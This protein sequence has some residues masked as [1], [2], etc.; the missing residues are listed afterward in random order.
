MTTFLVH[1]PIAVT[2][3]FIAVMIVGILASLNIPVSVMPSIDIPEI[4]VHINRKNVSTRE[5]EN[6][7]VAPLR[8]QLTRVAHLDDISSETR[9]EY[10]LIRLRFEYGTAVDLAFLEVNEKIDRAMT[11]F[12]RD[13]DRPKI[14]KASATDIPVF[15]LNIS[16]KE[17]TDTTSYFEGSWSP[18]FSELSDFASQVIRKRLEQLPDVAMVDMSGLVRSELLVIPDLAQLKAVGLTLDRL[19]EQVRDQNINLGSVLIHDGQYE[20]NIR[21]SSAIRNKKDVEDIYFNA[22]DRLLQLKDF[23]RV[24]QQPQRPK[25]VIISD[26]APAI[27]M[28]II[29]QSDAQMA[30]LRNSLSGIIA[31]FHDDYPHLNFTVTRDQTKLLDYAIS[32]LNQDLIWGGMLAFL[33]MFFF[34]GDIKSPLLIG[35]T[36]P[37]SLI[38]SLICF[39]VMDISINVISLS[40]LVLGVGMMIDNSIIVIDNIV[41]FRRNGLSVTQAC[42]KGSSEVFVPMLSSVLTTCAVFIPLIYL[43]GI[44]GALFFDEAMSIVVGAFVSLVM[45]VT[46]I[47]VYYRLFYLHQ[48]AYSTGF[49]HLADDLWYQAMYERSFKFIMRHQAIIWIAVALLVVAGIFAYRNLPKSKFPPLSKEDMVLHVDW[50]QNIDVEENN[51]RVRSLAMVINGNLQHYTAWVGEQQFL[52]DGKSHLSSSEALLYVKANGPEDLSKIQA[53]IS[54]YL[55]RSFPN[56]TFGYKETDNI[57]NLLFGEDEPQ[58]TARLRPTKDV[59][60]KWNNSLLST[61]AGIQDSLPTLFIEKPAVQ[62][63][64][65]LRVDPLRL[66]AY[67]VD[68]KT[69]YGKLRSAFNAREMLVITTGDGFMPVVLGENQQ[70][71]SNVLSEAYVYNGQGESYPLRELITEFRDYDL[72][73]IVAGQGGQYY[74]LHFDLPEQEAEVVIDKLKQYL[75]QRSLF[76]VDF[77]GRLFSS[78]VLIMELSVILLISVI[79]LYIILA[80]QFESLTLPLIVLLEIPIDIF[81]AFAFLK[82]FGAGINIMSLIGIVVMSGIIINDSILKIDTI[83]RLMREGHSLTKSI[84]LGGQRRLKSILMT[85]ITTVLAM[86]PLLLTPGLGSELQKPLAIALLGGMTVGTFVSLYFIPVCYYHIL[87]KRK[88]RLQL[89]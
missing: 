89:I 9:D 57:F 44:A 84:L 27:T 85:G 36:L 67:D 83:N 12:P 41:Q 87:R 32:N 6:T 76:D 50:N 24:V 49:K 52:L 73:T 34:L 26:D 46:L 10:S 22:G 51:R 20:Y 63:H 82:I 19:E 17:R 81:A 29:K 69:L 31:L 43:S 14:V 13:V 60:D 25:G 64:V 1:R 59:G 80:A 48:Q 35:I 78:R 40:G 86:I 68:L 56:A 42:V 47:P 21:F 66:A 3:I 70:F 18:R 2:V 53:E 71:I 28:A 88:T 5:L 74:P 8:Q 7:I 39:Y 58:L 4:T 45:S 37:A 11:N 30:D 72:K 38:V 15:Y 65:V 54:E 61:L 62:E 75:R 79:L 23:A 55:R 16:L 77:S 33:V